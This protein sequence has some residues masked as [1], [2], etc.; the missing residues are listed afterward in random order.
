M[1]TQ[2][3]LPGGSGN[4]AEGLGGQAQMR[5]R[6]KASKTRE[7]GESPGGGTW[8][9]WR[10]RRSAVE[11]GEDTLVTDPCKPVH[12]KGKLPDQIPFGCTDGD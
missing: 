1:H 5:H 6:S 4:W 9:A 12:R 8:E 11:G 2:S 10:R 7:D 3:P